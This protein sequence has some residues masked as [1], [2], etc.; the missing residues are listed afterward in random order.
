MDRNVVDKVQASWAQLEPHAEQVA[1]LFYGRLFEAD[2]SL[3]QLFHG[4]MTQQGRKLMSM[5]GAAVRGL[6]DLTTL[7]PVLRALGVR[8]VSYGVQPA[9]YDLVG[10]ALL[11]TLAQ[12]LGG[13]FTAQVEDAWTTV[14]KSMA[15]VMIQAAQESQTSA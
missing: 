10:A 4:D 2:P 1:E 15:G 3:R 9:H 6:D 12:G 11:A 5:I 13:A 8:H 7:M 14:Y